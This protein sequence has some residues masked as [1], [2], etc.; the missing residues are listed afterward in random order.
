MVPWILEEPR[1]RSPSFR[2]QNDDPIAALYP[3]TILG[4]N[5]SSVFHQSQVYTHSYLYFGLNEAKTQF[6]GKLPT[7]QGIITNPCV[8]KGTN[9]TIA[10]TSTVGSSDYDSCK[11]YVSEIIDTSVPCFQGD[12][13]EC[14]F[15]GVYQPPVQEK[16]DSGSS[17]NS[18]LYYAF[19]G[20]GY[21]WRFLGLPPRGIMLQ[22]LENGATEICNLD[23]A[24]LNDYNAKSKAPSSGDYLKDMCFSATYIYQLLTKGYKFEPTSRS[25]VVEDSINGTTISWAQGAIMTAI[26]N[27][28][29]D[30]TGST[31]NFASKSWL[32][33]FIGSFVGMCLILAIVLIAFAVWH[34]RSLLSHRG[35][36]SVNIMNTEDLSSVPLVG[37]E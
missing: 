26:N 27:L 14:S 22:E 20:F 9:R 34:Q 35:K 33:A 37:S 6:L 5:E 12:R 31:C 24:G 10:D 3:T 15:L 18:T 17:Q 21:S 4:A 28:D 16:D 7:S 1:H 36:A 30:Y 19:S 29:W 32:S 25:L 13:N 23:W 11:S 2:H 8:A